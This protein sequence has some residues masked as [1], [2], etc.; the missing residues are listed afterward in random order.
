MTRQQTLQAY[1]AV[2]KVDKMQFLPE[3]AINSRD[4][5]RFSNPGVLA[6]MWWALSAP[7]GWNRVNRTPKFR[8]C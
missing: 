3:S 7:S 2:C 4:V 5:V 1:E 6:V 8:G